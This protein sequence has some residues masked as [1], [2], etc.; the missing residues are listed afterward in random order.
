MSAEVP[1]GTRGRGR[2]PLGQL[3][4]IKVI[5][6]IR[7]AEEQAEIIP[8]FKSAYDYDRYGKRVPISVKRETIARDKAR[9]EGSKNPRDGS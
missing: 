6:T 3:D 9:A 1:D 2:V 4:I 5:P 7:E 8:G